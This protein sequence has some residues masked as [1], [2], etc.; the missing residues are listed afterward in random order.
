MELNQVEFL[1]GLFSLIFV[2]IAFIL[3]TKIM[4]K[5]FE[6]RNTD[7]I[8]FSLGWIGIANPWIPDAITFITILLTGAPLSPV[9]YFIIGFTFFPVLTLFWVIVIRKIV[10]AKY[11]NLVLIIYLAISIIFE[12]GFFFLLFTDIEQV[13][14]HTTPFQVEFGIF[15]IVCLLCM[16][17]MAIIV[18]MIFSIGSM[19]LDDPNFK[20]RGKIIFLAFIAFFTAIIVD[21]V[22]GAIDPLWI[23]FNRIILIISGILFY[24]GFILPERIKKIFITEI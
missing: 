3:A 20:L 18:W 12:I 16:V 19:K 7:F 21:S 5:Y 17:V 15:M 2:I 11:Y 1:Q 14:V 9:L 10:F 4:L 6:K 22:L 24:I 8:Y 23:I 13:G